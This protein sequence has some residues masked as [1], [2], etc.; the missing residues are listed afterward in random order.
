[1]SLKSQRRM[2]A[3]IFRAGLSRVWIDPEEI[4]RVQSAITRGEIQTLVREGRIRLLPKKGVSRGR[5][6]ARAGRKR[7]PGRRKGGRGLGKK[8]WVS[9]IRAVRRHLRVLRDRR[10][11]TPENYRKLLGLAKGGA[12]RSSSHVDDF[13]KSRQL[14]RKR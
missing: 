4:D 13:A 8:E 10:Q 2:A 5:A 11:L 3:N 6:R 9:K 1:M 14:L 7:G 12:F